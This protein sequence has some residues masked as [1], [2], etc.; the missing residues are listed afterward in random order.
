[1]EHMNGDGDV[2]GDVHGVRDRHGNTYVGTETGTCM[3]TG[4]AMM[5]GIGTRTGRGWLVMDE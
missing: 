4:T 1:V 2:D 5:A 3:V